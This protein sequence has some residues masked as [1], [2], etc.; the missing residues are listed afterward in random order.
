M[1]ISRPVRFF[2][3]LSQSLIK[4]NVGSEHLLMVDPG[5]GEHNRPLVQLLLARFGGL[6]AIFV[7]FAAGLLG[8]L[9]LLRF[10]ANFGVLSFLS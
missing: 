4:P 6:A 9:S 7:G 3:E 8:L 5:L 2:F 10:E 1:D